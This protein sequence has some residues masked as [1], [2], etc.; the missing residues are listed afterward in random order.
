VLP[1]PA[2]MAPAASPSVIDLSVLSIEEQM[3]INA[4]YLPENRAKLESVILNPIYQA[5]APGPDQ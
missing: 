2:N 3:K 4:D 5:Q 1:L